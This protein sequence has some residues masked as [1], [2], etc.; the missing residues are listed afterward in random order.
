[1]RP[2]VAALRPD[3]FGL[4]PRLATVATD[5]DSGNGLWAG[6]GNSF[7]QHG[8][9]GNRFA[10]A[11]ARDFGLR[12]HHC[13]HVISQSPCSAALHG[14][15]S[16]LEVALKGLAHH[17]DRSQPLDRC[18]AI[19]AGDNQPRRIAVRLLKY[20]PV[21]AESNEGIG[22]QRHGQ[23]QA[24]RKADLS[25]RLA[26]DSAVPAL[27]DSLQCALGDASRLQ[28]LADRDAG[29]FGVSHG[30]GLPLHARILAIQE[31]PAVAGAFEGR[32]E[33]GLRHI[34]QSFPGQPQLALDTAGY[35]QAPA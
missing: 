10:R 19:P 18:D 34:S 26:V 30:S 17:A 20:L 8:S 31:R 12:Q 1:M 22:M 14:I 13:H 2:S 3:E 15:P 25:G 21:H 27:K 23:R 4:P 33:T 24:P 16:A 7:N 9:H 29:P 6:P 28:K 32:D 11:G 35:G 5:L